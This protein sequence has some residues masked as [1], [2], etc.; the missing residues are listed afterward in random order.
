LK[1]QLELGLDDPLSQKL[2][3]VVLRPLLDD[4]FTE[5]FGIC[6]IL[7]HQNRDA[8][9]LH[10][11]HDCARPCGAA[12]CGPVHLGNRRCGKRCLVDGCKK[13]FEVKAEFFAERR[14]DLAPRPWRDGV[15]ESRQ[16][17]DPGVGQD[18]GPRR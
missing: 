17:Q 11:E 14:S 5:V 6:E 4:V 9:V 3:K 15:L 8:A 12:D 16:R 10:L 1:V 13:S 2:A 18:V 7:L